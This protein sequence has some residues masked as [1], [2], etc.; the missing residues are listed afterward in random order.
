MKVATT[1]N[2]I[3]IKMI[4]KKYHKQLHAHKFDVLNEMDQILGRHKD[5]DLVPKFIQKRNR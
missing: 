4:I 5:K 2:L 3:D 1:T